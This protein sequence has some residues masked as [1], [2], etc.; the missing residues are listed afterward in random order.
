MGGRFLIGHKV[1]NEYK[2][3][4]ITAAIATNGKS[5]CQVN[6]RRLARATVKTV[7][8]VIKPTANKIS[9]LTWTATSAVVINKPAFYLMRSW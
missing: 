7:R 6:R 9:N 2:M 4:T 5:C 3:N 8:T 1:A